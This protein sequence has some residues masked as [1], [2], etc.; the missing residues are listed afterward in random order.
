MTDTPSTKEEI[1]LGH[2]F[3]YYTF[4]PMVVLVFVAMISTLPL[5]FFG[6]ISYRVV[7]IIQWSSLAFGCFYI[8]LFGKY[9][10]PAETYRKIRSGEWGNYD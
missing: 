7:F 9:V 6:K 2:H 3:V 8:G 1:T 4:L 10:M 5:W